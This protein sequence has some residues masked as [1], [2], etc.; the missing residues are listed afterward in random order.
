MASALITIPDAEIETTLGVPAKAEIGE[1]D[2]KVIPAKTPEELNPFV[3]TTKEEFATAFACMTSFPFGRPNN[4][5]SL[6]KI[7]NL[8]PSF[9]PAT[10]VST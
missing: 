8:D 2:I 9:L 3:G 7:V 10:F 5:C 4:V 1:D 6:V